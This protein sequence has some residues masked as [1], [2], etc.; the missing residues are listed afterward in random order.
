MMIDRLI[1]YGLLAGHEKL[2]ETASRLVDKEG[3]YEIAVCNA[4]KVSQT[5]NLPV[6]S[7]GRL[8]KLA[9]NAP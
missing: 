7:E 2:L 5:N 6:A 9:S 4:D 8:N 3:C 1:R